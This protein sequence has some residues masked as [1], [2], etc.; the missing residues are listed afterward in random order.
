VLRGEGWLKEVLQAEG[1]ISREEAEW[2]AEVAAAS[3][4]FTQWLAAVLG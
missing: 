3:P 2:A 4:A 1:R